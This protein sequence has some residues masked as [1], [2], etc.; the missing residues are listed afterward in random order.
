MNKVTLRLF[1]ILALALNFGAYT[2]TTFA[3]GKVLKEAAEQAFKKGADDAARIA[4]RRVA[5]EANEMAAK[6]Q[7]DDIAKHNAAKSTQPVIEPLKR[8]VNPVAP[9]PKPAQAN[10]HKQSKQIV[11]DNPNIVQSQ[12]PMNIRTIKPKTADKKIDNIPNNKQAAIDTTGG[13]DF[14]VTSKG[15][16]VPIPKGA[17]GPNPVINQGGKTTGHAYIGGKGGTNKQVDTVRIMDPTQPRG[18]SPGY[19]KGYVK[20][21]NRLGQGV[22]ATS[23]RTLSNK[24]S[25]IPLD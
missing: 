17:T 24:N 7:L 1:A 20:Y 5:V 6:R 12:K 4:A 15:A 14:V 25:H 22:D 8:P 18:K 23:G 16:A 2:G 10:V 21:E 3:N 19:P 11:A 13:P 9:A